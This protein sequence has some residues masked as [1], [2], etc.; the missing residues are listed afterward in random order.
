[1]PFFGRERGGGGRHSGSGFGRHILYDY[2]RMACA[3]LG[4][5]GVDLYGGT[6]HSTMQHLL[7]QIS[8]ENIKRLSLHRTNRALDRYIEIDMDEL[9]AGYEMTRSSPQHVKHQRS[10]IKKKPTLADRLPN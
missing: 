8:P 3:N 9:R 10:T 2:W 5:G 4:I 6:R 1:M 7:E